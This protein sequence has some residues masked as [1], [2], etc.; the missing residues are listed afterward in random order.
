[1]ATSRTAMMVTG[2]HQTMPLATSANRAPEHD[3]LVRQRIEEGAGT[4][5]ALTRASQPSTPSDM[6]SSPPKTKV[7]QLAP[8]SM[9][10]AMTTGVASR[11]STVIPLAGVS[12]AD[13]PNV[14]ERPIDASRH[15]RPGVTAPS[16]TGRA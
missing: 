6:A 4:G 7:N 1:M 15:R 3:D 13:G 16:L 8:H 12:S 5:G 10:R 9:I 2:S 11:R 14:V